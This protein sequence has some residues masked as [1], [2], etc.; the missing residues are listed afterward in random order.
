DYL[1]ILPKFALGYEI[2]NGT[3]LYFSVSKGYKTGGYNEQSFYRVLQSSLSE[4]LMRNAF[5][6][7]PG[8]GGPGGPPPGAPGPGLEEQ[9]SY[10][11]ELSWTYELGGRG[12]FPDR[13]ISATFAIFYMNVSNI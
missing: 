5:R 4:S 7:M 8:G 12:V 1:E 11:P 2:S 3:S 9:M 13:N 6:G 10:D